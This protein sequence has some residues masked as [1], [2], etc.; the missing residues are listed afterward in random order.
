MDTNPKI[1]VRLRLNLPLR[2]LASLASLSGFNDPP[3]IALAF[4]TERTKKTPGRIRYG[5]ADTRSETQGKPSVCKPG[6]AGIKVDNVDDSG[7]SLDINDSN[8]LF[9]PAIL[10]ITSAFENQI[11]KKAR[12]NTQLVHEGIA[13]ISSSSSA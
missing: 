7:A 11:G 8:D 2:V 6:S 9:S 12:G 1:L 5:S 13:L 4:I 3:I 10:L